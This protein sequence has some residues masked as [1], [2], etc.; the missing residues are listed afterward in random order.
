MVMSIPQHRGKPFVVVTRERVL[1]AHVALRKVGWIEVHERGVVTLEQVAKIPTGN[2][3]V[4]TVEQLVAVGNVPAKCWRVPPV[5][6][7]VLGLL[8]PTERAPAHLAPARIRPLVNGQLHLG[9]M[10]AASRRP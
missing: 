7:L 2:R 5:A 9:K 8:P 3:G 4:E 6:D 10:Y 1:V